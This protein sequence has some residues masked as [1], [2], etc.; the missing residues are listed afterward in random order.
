MDTTIL[1]RN[2]RPSYNLCALTDTK[3]ITSLLAKIRA[4]DRDGEERLLKLVYPELRK[5]AHYHLKRERPDHTLQA[6]ALVHEAY[7]RI[8]GAEPVAWRDRAHFFA[9]AARK[10]R[11]ILVDYARARSTG[12]R[13]GTWVRLS[14][15]AVANLGD[16]GLNNDILAVDESLSR[17]EQL[18][19]HAARV[20]ELRFFAGMTEKETAEA[21]RV[22]LSSVKRTWD[23]ARAWLFRELSR[24]Q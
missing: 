5:L 20:I 18:D 2:L 22:P 11:Q 16:A 1:R 12:K 9:L 10:M 17:L 4:G 23:F 3:V 8:F 13:G 7:L 14:L 19:P 15:D 21:L 24:L 6:T